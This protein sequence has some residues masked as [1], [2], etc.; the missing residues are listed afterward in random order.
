MSERRVIMHYDMDAFYASVEIREN[1]SLRGKPI[2]V[3]ENIVTTASYEARKF[4]VKSAMPL[5]EARRLC[6]NLISLPVRKGIYGEVSAKIQELVRRITEK[7]EF[8]AFDEGYL[9]LTEVIEGYPSR[10]YFAKRFQRGIEKNTQLTC[11]VGVGYNK[12][13][14]KIAS[15]INKPGGIYIFRSREEFV[16]YIREKDVR[17]LP[18][19]GKK[20]VE[21]LRGKLQIERVG[22]VYRYSLTELI[23][24]LG[25]SRGELIYQYSRGYD[26]REVD[27]KRKTHSIGNENTFKY[28]LETREEIDKEMEAL[29]EKTYD[30]L[31]NKGFLCKTVVVKVRY[32]DRKT[33]TRSKTFEAYTGDRIDLHEAMSGLIEE[34][35]ETD[36]R[37]SIRLLGVS[38][39]NLSKHRERQLTFQE[40]EKLSKKVSLE[41]LREK[42]NTIQK[43][44]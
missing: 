31:K 21:E 33:I 42:I 7:T 27:Y 10:E 19:V 36:E 24:T 6:P 4:G 17:I 8:I 12:L 35:E 34:V 43:K 5:P 9:D 20:M 18:G 37:K 44:G 13:T 30:R 11:S 1:P 32:S 22:D 39:G 41:L 26:Y 28:Y 29:F 25:R 15:D 14:A 23:A 40:R 3:G 2:V 16:E 38:F